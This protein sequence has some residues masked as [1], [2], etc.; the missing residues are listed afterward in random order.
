[1]CFGHFL[2]NQ[3]IKQNS[4]LP[5]QS[6]S[7]NSHIVRIF[8]TN[9]LGIEKLYVRTS[10][11]QQESQQR[12]EQYKDQTEKRENIL[13]WRRREKSIS[14]SVAHWTHSIDDWSRNQ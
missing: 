14:G 7:S 2:R 11:K 3:K 9:S 1:M 6:W 12:K 13:D 10:L 8:G 4:G 5:W